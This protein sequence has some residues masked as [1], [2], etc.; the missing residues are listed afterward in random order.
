MQEILTTERLHLRP[1]LDKDNSDLLEMLA[2]RE[3][4]QYMDVPLIQNEEQ[5]KL[6]LKNIQS[7]QD[8]ILFA[9][10]SKEEKKVIGSVAFIHLNK[11]H[12]FA[13]LSYFIHHNYQRKGFAIEALRALI[14]HGFIDKLLNRME[15]QVHTK[16]MASQRLLEKL[17][18]KSEGEL[19]ENFLIGNS[20]YNS[21][22]YALIKRDWY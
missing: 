10:E 13:S 14:N 17:G 15:A 22:L 12:Y 4:M 5:A 1:F 20:F 7:K 3:L 8:V 6:W 9:L 18:F 21:Y 2:N 11:D 16:N 19:K